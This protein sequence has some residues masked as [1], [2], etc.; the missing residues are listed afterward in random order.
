MANIA[1]TYPPMNALCTPFEDI[2][3]GTFVTEIDEVESKQR[4]ICENW[5][6]FNEETRASS[7]P[8]SHRACL[9]HYFRQPMI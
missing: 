1:N 3:V 5:K 8:Q 6:L 2:V 4:S 7:G 9:C